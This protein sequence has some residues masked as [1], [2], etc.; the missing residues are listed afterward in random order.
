MPDQAVVSATRAIWKTDGAGDALIVD[1]TS[2]HA[3]D[4]IEGAFF[5]KRV[6]GKT[7]CTFLV[8]YAGVVR[9]ETTQ[10]QDQWAKPYG[11]YHLCIQSVI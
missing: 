7:R 3:T 10:E 5:R 4:F 2:L 8:G 9:F 11:A 1:R 6:A